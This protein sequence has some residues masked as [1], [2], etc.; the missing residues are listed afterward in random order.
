MFLHLVIQIFNM[1]FLYLT[2]S[3]LCKQNAI[4]SILSFRGEDGV[5]R[6]WKQKDSLGFYDSCSYMV[7][8][9]LS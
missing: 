6:K 7:L 1:V 2:K 4:I 3:S 9:V 5:G 8:F